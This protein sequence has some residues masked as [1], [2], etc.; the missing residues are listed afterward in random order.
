MAFKNGD[1][2]RFVGR[3]DARE[4]GKYHPDYVQLFDQVGTV[5][6]ADMGYEVRF[7]GFE[8]HGDVPYD[9][10]WSAPRDWFVCWADELEA[11]E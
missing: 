6:D 4:A 9:L 1:K 5:V 7:E 8:W 11:A 10:P 2:V 3:Q